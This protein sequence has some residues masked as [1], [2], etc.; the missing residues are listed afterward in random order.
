MQPSAQVELRQA[1]TAYGTFDA[2]ANMPGGLTQPWDLY[3]GLLV[4]AWLVSQIPGSLCILPK[5]VK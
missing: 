5:G 2:L 4:G 3:S 1:L